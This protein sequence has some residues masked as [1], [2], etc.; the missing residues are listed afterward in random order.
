VA[1]ECFLL[2]CKC[3]LFY[4]GSWFC[5][6]LVC[7]VVVEIGHMDKT[8]EVNFCVDL[9]CKVVSVKSPIIEHVL[10]SKQFPIYF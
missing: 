8:L 9:I 5:F 1:C 2:G 7:K 3:F 4:F 10:I 6:G